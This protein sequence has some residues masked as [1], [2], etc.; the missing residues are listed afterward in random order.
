MLKKVVIR[1][2]REFEVSPSLD[3]YPLHEKHSKK[4]K[5]DSTTFSDLN[6]KLG[7]SG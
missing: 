7:A 1:D 6:Q 3:F 2:A 4:L 5:D